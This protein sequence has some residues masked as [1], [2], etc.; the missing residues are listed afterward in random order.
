MSNSYPVSLVPLPP[1]HHSQKHSHFIRSSLWIQTG[2]QQGR[3]FWALI[4]HFLI[5]EKSVPAFRI[6]VAVSWVLWKKTR[7][8]TY[9]CSSNTKDNILL[10]LSVDGRGSLQLC[11]LF[12]LLLF[13]LVMMTVK[14]IISELQRPE[15]HIK[16]SVMIFFTAQLASKNL[17]NSII[18][19]PEELYNL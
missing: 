16:K 9:L 14:A 3:Y 4:V 15:V 11:F 12:V 17:K 18:S 8:N 6:S 7:D 2:S 13:T 19:F 5:W 1:S 10:Q